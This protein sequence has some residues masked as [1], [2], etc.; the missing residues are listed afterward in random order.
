M[1]APRYFA[2]AVA[3]CALAALVAACGSS[4]T[5]T[6]PPS[7]S[8][9]TPASSTSTPA[10][11]S[12]AVATITKNWEAFFDAAK[13]PTNTRIG[14]LENGSQFPPKDLAATGIASSATAQVTSVSSVTASTAVVKYNVLLD[15]TPALKDQTGT[16]V[17]QDGTW[18]VG[19]SS[20]CSL[21]TLEKTSGFISSVP[22][23]CRTGT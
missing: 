13:T 22:S 2:Q 9:S 1:N 10:S 23:V 19:I 17:Y 20:F 15:G 3:A 8:T 14:L 16:A 5:T 7:S 4:T 21:L 6:T 18:K 12:A 11:S